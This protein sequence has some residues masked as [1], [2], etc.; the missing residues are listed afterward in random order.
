[1]KEY[2]L[3]LQGSRRSLN[4][5]FV[6]EAAMILVEKDAKPSVYF[7]QP[8]CKWKKLLHAEQSVNEWLERNL[9]GIPW[10]AGATPYCDVIKVFQDS[11]KDA[12]VIYVKGL[13]KKKWIQEILPRK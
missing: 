4:L 11:L 5:F 2:V 6:K 9:H 12:A 8:P 3:D 13:E 7:F 1:M 10:E